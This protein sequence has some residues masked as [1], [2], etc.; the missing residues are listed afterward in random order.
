MRF[1]VLSDPH[2]FDTTTSDPGPAFDAHLVKGPTL[3]AESGRILEAALS[4]IA[5]E[6]PAFLLVCGDLSSEGELASHRL[7]ARE[8]DR[9][10]RAGVPVFV[11]PGNHDVRNP[12]ASRY[13]GDATEPV[14]SVTPAEF[15]AIYGPFGYDA[16]IRRDPDSLSY[17]A[18]PVPG[19]WLLALDSCQYGASRGVEAAH[20]GIPV[21]RGRLRPSTMRW[22]RLVLSD[23]NRHA[24]H[25]IAMLHHGIVEQFRG[26]RTWL[27][28]YV[29]DGSDA[30]SRLLAGGGVA[31]VFT[32]HTH[33]QDVTRR[34]F[35]DGR[36]I[37]DVQ[38][39]STVSWPNPWRIVE[40]DA[41]GRMAIRSGFVTSIDGFDGDFPEYSRERLRRWLQ[42]GLRSAMKR[43]GATEG[44]ADALAP[45]AASAGLSFFHGDEP[46]T[47]RNFDT[48]G[49]DL[50]GDI[51]AAM[52]NGAFRDFQTDLPP[53][54]N[55]VTLELGGAP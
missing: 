1:A 4:A 53:A 31:A 28:D 19:L 23:A 51:F 6:K 42:A 30:V 21:S 27:P 44:T 17:V 2:V 25:V 22:A 34:V 39:G 16:A 7:A 49:L 41:G 48:T 33:S 35:P 12:Q 52:A 3:L 26:E 11:V 46:G 24:V 13:S 55:D 50:G 15:S 5:A 14:A 54:D 9:I 29:I 37:S 43:V 32:G 18:E 40:I 36:V 20:R 47:A 8:L 38:T 10:R 45:Q